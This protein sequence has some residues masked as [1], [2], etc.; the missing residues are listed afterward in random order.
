MDN[1]LAH[2]LEKHGSKRKAAKSLGIPE[3]TF[4]SWLKKEEQGIPI[5]HKLKGV[6]TLYSDKGDIKQRWV[7][8]E[9]DKQQQKELLL[10]LVNG[11]KQQV[12]R[13]PPIES[14]KETLDDLLSCY[15]LTDY[16]LGML[17]WAG[18]TGEN[19]DT[20]LAAELL[21]KW[22]ASAI[23]SAPASNTAIL[24]NLGDFLHYDSLDA[25]TPMSGHILDADT[26]LPKLVNMAIKVLREVVN[27]LLTKHENVH[28]IM[29][30]GN[31]DM[32]S[33]VWLRALFA[34]KYE[35]EPRITVDNTHSPYYAYEWGKTSLFFHHGHKKRLKNISETFAGMYREMFGR[36][37]YSYAHLGHLHHVESKE[38]CLM[39][40]EQHPTLSAKDAYASRGGYLANRGASV[41]TYSKNNGEVSRATVRPE[42]IQ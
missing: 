1:I 10:A 15:I 14:P 12:H 8:T 29:A 17:S 28:I 37:K 35:L 22:F 5:D 25:V 20:D 3:S 34:E 6:S 16:H 41:I 11:F 21:V 42:M 4:R 13:Q 7:K 9:V 36:T 30:E 40:V 32:A 18:E 24:G 26:R 33:S 31:H 2:A 27:M 39:I 19:W 38:D 23:D